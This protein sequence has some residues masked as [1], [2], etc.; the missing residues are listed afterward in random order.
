MISIDDFTRLTDKIK[1]KIFLLLGRALL[2]A[3]NNSGKIQ[4]IQVQALKDETITD[5][6]RFQEYGLETY[7]KKGSAEAAVVFLNGNREHGIALCV[8]DRE[9]RPTDL[10]EGEVML[11][12][13]DGNTKIYIK[14]GLIE[15]TG[16]GTLEFAP[17]SSKIKTEID[18]LIDIFN[19]HV[20]PETG[21]NTQ[22][23]TTSMTK[24]TQEDYSST[25][26]K[27]S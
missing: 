10:I 1:R 18:T 26:I 11:Y 3:V 5:I 19:A 7:P 4:K 20:H 24:K 2:T 22:P 12:H 27:I 15:I 13:L 9:Y 21:G 25:E 23:P 14:E 8:Q 17:L 6:E 16:G